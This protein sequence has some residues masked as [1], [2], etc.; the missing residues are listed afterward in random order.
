MANSETLMLQGNGGILTSP[1]G[2]GAGVSFTVKG[3][4]RIRPMP[5]SKKKKK[6]TT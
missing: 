5:Y 4:V 3:V 1:S 6:T 2:V